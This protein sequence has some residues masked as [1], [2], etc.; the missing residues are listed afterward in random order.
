MKI[1]VI[2][3]HYVKNYGSVLQTYATQ[4]LLKREQNEVFIANYVL[5]NSVGMRYMDTILR[6]HAHKNKLKKLMMKLIL[7]PTIWKWERVFGGFLKKYIH[8]LGAEMYDCN[9]L[10]EKLPAA[11]IYCTGSDQVWNPQSNSGLLPAYFCE[12][13]PKDKKIVSLAASF[14][15][16]EIEDADRERLKTYLQ[17]YDLISVREKT[18]I[19]I[20]KSMELKGELV[21]DPTLIVE[22]EF[23]KR[24]VGKRK[25][26]EDYVLVYQLNSNPKFDRYAVQAAE[27]LGKKLVRICTRYDQMMK[28]GKA[29]M[30]PNVEQWI[31]L[32]YYA[33]LVIT[34]SFHGTVFSL[35]FEKPFV[36]IYPPRFSE[37]VE[38][39][40]SLLN[41]ESRHIEDYQD[42]SVLEQNIDYPKVN[43]IMEN[44]RTKSNEFV[45]KIICGKD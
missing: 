45:E 4:E 39:L 9:S 33:D 13:A 36:D 19:E 2:T 11:D 30:I 37:R 15:M 16:R 35:I 18:G 20:L 1:I 24:L 29:V 17:K 41:L 38:S 32:F 26:S 27:K 25:V 22:P 7:L 21:L 23:W 31:S 43:A 34:D 14:G 6:K 42:F 44:E 5:K 40:L 10:K 12:F 3:K 8:V 28:S